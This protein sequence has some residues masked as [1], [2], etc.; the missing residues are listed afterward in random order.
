MASPQAS[1]VLDRLDLGPIKAAG[2]EL[3]GTQPQISSVKHRKSLRRNT[4]NCFGSLEGG[5]EG[6]VG[7]ASRHLREIESLVEKANE[8]ERQCPIPLPAFKM[9]LT[10][11]QY[12]YRRDDGVIVVPI[13]CLRD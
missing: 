10:A 12:G 6:E 7:E 3:E 1:T 2:D 11:T 9:V 4:A 5:R 13:G 8:K